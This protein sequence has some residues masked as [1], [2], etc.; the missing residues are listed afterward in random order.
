METILVSALG[1]KAFLARYYLA[2]DPNRVQA[3]GQIAT[4][5]L[6]KLRQRV[7]GI[8][9]PDLIIPLCTREAMDESLPILKR[10]LSS[11]NIDV[12]ETPLGLGSTE[13]QEIV[14]GLLNKIPPRCR[15]TLD[16]T[17]GFRSYPFLF[18]IAIQYLTVLREDVEIDGVYYGMFEARPAQNEPAPFV[19]LAILLEMMEWIYAV[20]VFRDTSNAT[21]LAQLLKPLGKAPGE[22]QIKSIQRDL[23]NYSRAYWLACPIELGMAA[24]KLNEQLNRGIPATLSERV[25]LAGELFGEIQQLANKFMLPFKKGKSKAKLT[26][27]ELERQA[28]IIDNFIENGQV[29]Q[30]LGLIREW[31][32]SA[33]MLHNGAD[34]EWLKKKVREGEEIK[35]LLWKMNE[36]GIE[37][38]QVWFEVIQTRNDIYH[39]GFG[40]DTVNISEEQETEIR[41]RWA[42]VKSK[43]G[44]QDYWR[45][46]STEART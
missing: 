8:P 3:E 5:A 40:V 28:R 32:I 16:L 21:R 39:H 44:N 41:T 24:N 26:T 6:V 2:D 31:L 29:N 30:A 45:L 9:F 43:L 35:Q 11:I 18:F 37:A 10:E 20:R 13:L 23:R 42:T 14:A 4:T 34:R 19:D 36:L 22:G 27:K 1:K 33:V 25:P 46:S 15:L 7:H 38:G 12:L 17:H